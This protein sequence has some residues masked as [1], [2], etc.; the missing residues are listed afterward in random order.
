MCPPMLAAIEREKPALLWLA[1]P[2]NPTGH[3]LGRRAD[4]DA[5]VDAMAPHG[6]VVFDEAY[7]A[8]RRQATPATACVA[9]ALMWQ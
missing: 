6:L 4:L 2:N 8:L 9:P 7:A 5:L 1:C 3:A